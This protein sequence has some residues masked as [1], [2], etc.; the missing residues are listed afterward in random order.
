MPQQSTLTGAMRLA[1]SIVKQIQR[2]TLTVTGGAVPISA[3][4]NR[5]DLANT[6]F[7]LPNF[8][9]K[10]NLPSGIGV[11][12]ASIFLY[13]DV[14]TDTTLRLQ[15]NGAYATAARL[16]V[17]IVEFFPGVFRSIQR[18]VI[19]IPAASL[20]VGAT[21]NKVAPSRS[22]IIPMGWS[23][24]SD[25]SDRPPDALF[26]DLELSA[27]GGTVTASRYNAGSTLDLKVAYQIAE[28]A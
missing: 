5:V 15:S 28:F 16:P 2:V 3:T 20:S 1:P 25:V 4:I 11:Y 8:P 9:P 14:Q 23:G 21:I 26:T 24:D 22:L 17:D 13:V 6:L 19:T 12:T 18:G 27:D 10:T 7:L